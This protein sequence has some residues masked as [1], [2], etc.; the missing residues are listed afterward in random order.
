MPSFHGRG[1]IDSSEEIPSLHDSIY[2]A[3]HIS[4]TNSDETGNAPSLESWLTATVHGLNLAPLSVRTIGQTVVGEELHPGIEKNSALLPTLTAAANDSNFRYGKGTLLS[5]ITEKKSTCTITASETKASFSLSANNPRRKKSFST[6][7]IAK[8]CESYDEAIAMNENQTQPVCNIYAEP[9]SPLSNPPIRASTPPGMPSWDQ[10]QMGR[11]HSAVPQVSRPSLLHRLF[12]LPV[13]SHSTSTRIHAG[14]LPITNIT[15]SRYRPPRSAYG[16]MNKHPF[17]RAPDEPSAFSNQFVSTSV[18]S[19]PISGPGPLQTIFGVSHRR[20]PAVKQMPG[21]TRTSTPIA[22]PPASSISIRTNVD[23]STAYQATPPSSHLAYTPSSLYKLPKHKP[24]TH[25]HSRNGSSKVPDNPP[26]SRCSQY[27]QL[28]EDRPFLGRLSHPWRSSSPSRQSFQDRL[29]DLRVLGNANSISTTHLMS[30]ALCPRY[31]PS[32]TFGSE[33][34]VYPI[35]PKDIAQMS[36][37]LLNL[38]T[39]G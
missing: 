22:A 18:A 33:Y 37:D 6:G 27:E 32:P 26:P 2:E 24:C 17:L 16:P 25:K 4:N 14:S 30:G 7:D 11:I 28:I 5:T 10:H 23:I 29:S 15:M 31:P 3:Y 34:T 35:Y 13:T 38:T 8:A 36:Y 20:N 9:K 1:Q 39:T 12:A 21:Q 19:K